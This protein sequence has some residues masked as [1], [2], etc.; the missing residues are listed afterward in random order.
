MSSAAAA[1]T[2]CTRVHVRV[3][4]LHP[5]MA[6]H[7]VLKETLMSGCQQPGP[8]LPRHERNMKIVV[9]LRRNSPFPGH[10]TVD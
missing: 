2:A 1:C 4:R 9:T 10:R 8:D 5:N 6:V 3:R 7:A